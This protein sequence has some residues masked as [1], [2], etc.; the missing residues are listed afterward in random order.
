MKIV[1]W[2]HILVSEEVDVQC[3]ELFLGLVVVVM[4]VE[5]GSLRPAFG[6]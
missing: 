5:G 1:D 2:R 3:D 4:T 6:D